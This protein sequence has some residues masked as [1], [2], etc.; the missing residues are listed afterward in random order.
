MA[1]MGFGIP[2]TIAVKF[3]GPQPAITL[4]GDMGFAL[5]LGEL[6]SCDAIVEIFEAI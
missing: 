3:Y 1:A 5:S 6:N 4:C 2:M